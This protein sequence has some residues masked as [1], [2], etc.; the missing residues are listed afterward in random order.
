MQNSNHGDL[1]E[2][3]DTGIVSF[4]LKKTGALGSLNYTTSCYQKNMEGSITIFAENATIKVGGK[5]LNT[6]DYQETNGFDITDLPSSNPANDYGY[7]EGSMSNHDLIIN[8]VIRALNGEEK[9]MTNAYE[10]L[11]VVEIIEEMYQKS[12]FYPSVT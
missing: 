7:Y 6:I 1:I 11:K 4:R 5:Y 2:F 8:N 10:G 9:I 12:K 3:E